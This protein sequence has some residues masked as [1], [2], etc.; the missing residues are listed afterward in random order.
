MDYVKKP[1]HTMAL[2]IDSQQ[3][4]GNVMFQWVL[5][6]QPKTPIFPSHIGPPIKRKPYSNESLETLLRKTKART[7]SSKTPK[8]CAL[9]K[10]QIQTPQ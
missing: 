2:E 3:N 8:I 4:Q 10:T 9:R 1:I 7:H 5:V 6:K